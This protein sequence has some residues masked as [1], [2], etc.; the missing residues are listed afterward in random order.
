MTAI[1]DEGGSD[2]SPRATIYGS[3][4]KMRGGGRTSSTRENVKKGD[5]YRKKKKKKGGL[6]DILSQ[7]R[8]V[9][10]SLKTVHGKEKSEK[11]EIKNK[12]DLCIRNGATCGNDRDLLNGQL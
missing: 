5:D 12:K 6:R 7:K 4:I 10:P 11:R 1:G 2:C 9:D 3:G 8:E